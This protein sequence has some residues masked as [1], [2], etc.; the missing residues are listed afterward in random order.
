MAPKGG[1]LDRDR[2]PGQERKPQDLPAAVPVDPVGHQEHLARI[3][4]SITLAEIPS[5][6][7]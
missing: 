1:R 5:R 2:R 3:P 7:R 4:T 6:S